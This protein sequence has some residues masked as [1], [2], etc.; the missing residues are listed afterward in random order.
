MDAEQFDS[1][2]SLLKKYVPEQQMP[3]VW[4]LLYG[5]TPRLVCCQF[6][7]TF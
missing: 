5:G 1:F 2:E 4:R 6:F 7:V 3:E